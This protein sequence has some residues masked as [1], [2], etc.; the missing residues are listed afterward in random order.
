[1]LSER[2]YRVKEEVREICIRVGTPQPTQ[3]T[4]TPGMLLTLGI[5]ELTQYAGAMLEADTRMREAVAES[6]A[7]NS[8]S[9]FD[10]RR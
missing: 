5:F 10:L 2:N 4:G 6:T 8:S 7:K 9:Q 1:M 3:V